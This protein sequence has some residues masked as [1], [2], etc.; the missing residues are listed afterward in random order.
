[1][2]GVRGR[3]RS[4]WSALNGA[5]LR[6]DW[7]TLDGVRTRVVECGEPDAPP[8]V[9][10]HG[11]G[12]HAEAFIHNIAPLSREHRVIAYDL[13][14]HGWS[15][16]PDRSYEI[17]GYVR[18][19]EALVDATG[20]SRLAICGQSLGGW[21]AARYSALHVD[22][23]TRLVLVG[24]GGFAS[25]PK[26]LALVQAQSRDAA[27]DASPEAVRRR[28]EAIMAADD[29][30]TD[31][32]LAC[33]MELYAQPDAARRM[34]LALVLQDPV[35]RA[36]NLLERDELRRV[37]CPTLVVSG[38]AD[39]VVPP[40]SSMA[41]DRLLPDSSFVSVP[42]SGHWPQFEQPELFNAHALGFLSP[43]PQH[44]TRQENHA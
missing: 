35:T 19:L 32:L 42:D 22:R 16:A 13:P 40:E 3:D 39:R 8:L 11:T 38:E 17:E 36:R 20:A 28:L 23:V 37:A 24:P 31:E 14:A 10:I 26:R 43:S 34:E 7:R 5:R 41:I 2:S 27:R 44:R 12:G 21:I 18:H 33:R 15:S 4:F 30:V 6:I 29:H 9:L 1:M 25:D